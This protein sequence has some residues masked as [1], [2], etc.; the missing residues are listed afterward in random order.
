MQNKAPATLTQDIKGDAVGGSGAASSGIARDEHGRST[1]FG[2]EGAPAAKRA[3]GEGLAQQGRGERDLAQQGRGGTEVLE[4]QGGQE[5]QGADK[6]AGEHD[7]FEE[8]ADRMRKKRRG[9][10]AAAKE[11]NM[12][13][14][15]LE[16]Q[17]HQGDDNILGV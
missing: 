13:L 3:R 14:G 7:W 5:G 9:E 8:T 6:R 1:D 12:D 16:G 11:G 4:Q 17:M 10:A 2:N 15:A